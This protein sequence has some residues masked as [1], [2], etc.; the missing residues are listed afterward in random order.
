RTPVHD[1]FAAID[2][3]LFVQADENLSAA[4]REV[5]VHSEVLAAPIDGSPQPLHLLEDGAAVVFAPLPHALHKTF[6]PQLLAGGSLFHQ[7]PLHHHLGGN[8]G[9]IGAGQPQSEI[10]AHAVPADDDVHLCLV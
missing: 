6:A 2:Q 8:A 7:L 1:V 3:P 9:V 4:G 5:F 10:T